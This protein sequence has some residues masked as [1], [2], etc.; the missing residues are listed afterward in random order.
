MIFAS[1]LGS[2]HTGV[3]PVEFS[4]VIGGGLSLPLGCAPLLEILG[5]GREKMTN[6]TQEMAVIEK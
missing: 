3:P 5:N 4:G 6:G 2:R 1:F